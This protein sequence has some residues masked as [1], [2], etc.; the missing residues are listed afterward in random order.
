MRVLGPVAALVVVALIGF[1]VWER[2]HRPLRVDLTLTLNQRWNGRTI[3]GHEDLPAGLDIFENYL[4]CLI[5]D[6]GHYLFA[7]LG[8]N[9]SG[10]TVFTV[11]RIVWQPEGT[12]DYGAPTLEWRPDGSA[13]LASVSEGGTKIFIG[14][15]PGVKK[16]GTGI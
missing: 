15:V 3:M 14:V 2:T 1:Y 12:A 8:T 5:A 11:D 6:N 9:N 13:I 10:P 4:Q 7:G 16:D